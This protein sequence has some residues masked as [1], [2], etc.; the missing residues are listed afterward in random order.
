MTARAI[1]LGAV[2]AWS[3]GTGP[4]RADGDANA[5]A[6]EHFR[7]GQA[8]FQIGEYDRALAEYQIAF[9]LSH[10]PSLVFNIALCHDR[11]NRPDQALQAFRRYLLLAPEGS[12]AD[13]ARESIAR[14]TLVV[15]KLSADREARRA[16]ADAQRRDEAARHS[17]AAHSAQEQQ[18][19][20]IV[21]IIVLSGGVVALGG[22][23]MHAAAWQTRNRLSDP[24]DLDSYAA[25]RDTFRLRRTIAIG[26][27]TAGA[28]TIATGLILGQTLLRPDDGPQISASL[29]PG[30]AAV[31]I[32]WSR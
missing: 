10:E 19:R 30:G 14:L 5:N 25:D 13:E 23:V 17:A 9:D 22:G 7:Q 29:T 12:V 8:F 11:S 24:D 16:A 27:Y 20:R 4:A 3:L 1:A 32:G 18:G 15:D 26:A 31:A 21:R 2:L 6:K 28:L